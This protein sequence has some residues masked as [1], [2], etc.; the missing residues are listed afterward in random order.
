MA[1]IVVV[2]ALEDSDL[3][4]AMSSCTQAD[5]RANVKAGNMSNSVFGSCVFCQKRGGCVYD[6]FL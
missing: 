1:N 6:D 2:L 3:N 5:I 4:S